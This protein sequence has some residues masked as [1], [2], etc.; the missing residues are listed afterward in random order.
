[1]ALKINK[2]REEVEIEEGADDLLSKFIEGCEGVIRI[3]TPLGSCEVK[4]I[5]KGGEVKI[6][7][8]KKFK[9]KRK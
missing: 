6:R 1:M 2:E 9:I 3:N 5:K 7:K 8:P 4:R